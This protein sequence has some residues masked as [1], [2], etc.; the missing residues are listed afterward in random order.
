MTHNLQVFQTVLAFAF[1]VLLC[2]LLKQGGLISEEHGPLFARLLT[3][4]V[5]PV[6]I[7]AKLA[8]QPIAPHQF[9]LVLAMMGTVMACLAVSWAVGALL[10]LARPQIGALMIASSFGASTLI[11]YPLVQYVF[12]HNPGA[13]AD[14]ILISELGVGLPI[15]TLCLWVA[16]YFGEAAAG[17]GRQTIFLDYVRSPICIALVA[18]LLASPLRLNPESLWLAPFLQAAHMVGEAIALLACLIL[19]IQLKVRSV[20]GIWLLVLITAAIQLGLHPWLANLQANLYH[21]VP[22]SRQVLVLEAAM[23][24][25]ILGVVFTTRYR[26]APEMNASL[27]FSNIVLSMIAVPLVFGLLCG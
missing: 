7:F 11:G 18:G 26:C 19:A 16:M 8:T 14:A 10:K 17:G 9:L 13:M 6:V 2:V 22:E 3:Q 23:P 20:K 4:V 5:L 15:F 27:V 1:V 21:F 24:S 12:P 25:A